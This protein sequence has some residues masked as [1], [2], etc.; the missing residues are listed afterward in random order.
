MKQSEVFMQSEGNAWFAR[1]RDRLGQHD[2]VSEMIEANGIKPKR[3]LEI[4]CA[5]GWR[6]QKLAEKYGCETWGVEPSMH[7]MAEARHNHLPVA[8]CDATSMRGVL[9][10][11]F[12]LVIYGFCLYVTDPEDWFQI[13]AEGDRVLA[14]GGYLIVHDF[15]GEDQGDAYAR[16]YE[17]RPDVLAYHVD[18]A[19]FWLAHPWYELVTT[20]SDGKGDWISLLRKH[21]TIEVLP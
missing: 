16:R 15:E 9:P 19:G 17:H 7:A 4:G 2:P 5:N 6:L 20:H 10:H 13:V 3:L 11:S 18:F 14:P 8:Q 12:D 21:A 1:N